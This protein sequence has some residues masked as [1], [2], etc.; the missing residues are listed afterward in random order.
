MKE[1]IYIAFGEGKDLEWWQMVDR[2]VV[3]FI[4][5]IVFVRLSGRRSFGMKSAFDNTI[6]ILLGAILSRAVTGASAFFPTLAASLALALLH[7]LFAWLSTKSHT[8]GRLIKGEA[9]VIYK[10]GKL[11]RVN[12]RRN[13][14]TEK[15]LKEGLHNAINSD[16]LEDAELILLERDGDIS[17]VKKKVE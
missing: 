3:V 1:F 14:I 6:V 10:D 7:R 11:N 15:D 4:L 8:F 2:A 5:S 16:E 12:M 13:F 9:I 17:V